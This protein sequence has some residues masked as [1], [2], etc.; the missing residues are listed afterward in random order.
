VSQFVDEGMRVT[1]ARTRHCAMLGAPLVLL[2]SALLLSACAAVAG[3]AQGVAAGDAVRHIARFE[4]PPLDEISGIT[5]SSYPGVFWVHNDSGDS[6]R[7]FGVDLEG[8]VIFPA[9]LRD[10]Y[11][12]T[13]FPGLTVLGA[14]NVDWEDITQHGGMLYI[15]DI[16]NN[17]NARRDLG[18]Y[19][20]AEPNPRA[21]TETRA[22]KFL[23]IRYPDQ[24]AFPAEQWHFDAE[25]LFVDDGKLYLITKHRRPGR[26]NEWE[27]GAKLY[28]LDTEYTD[29]KNE[30]TYVGTHERLTLA[31]G[32]DLSPDGERLAV[33]SYPALWVFERPAEGDNWF[34]GRARWLP[35]NF[36]RTRQVEAIA[37]VDDETLVFA[38]EER[39]LFEVKLESLRPAE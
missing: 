21:T 24:H 20:L 37:W 4:H 33:I 28:R 18:I 14:S 9:F 15:G 27:P 36:L 8:N 17:G 22:L 16:G 32:A 23:P 2:G 1:N 26:I 11:A 29:R 5:R 13:P 30:L 6:A 3:V 7:I 31:T 34:E 19:V 25:S 39:D 38:N 12:T 10:Q 35:L